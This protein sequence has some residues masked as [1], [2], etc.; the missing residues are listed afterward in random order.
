MSAAGEA[1]A[2]EDAFASGAKPRPAGRVRE[3]GWRPT[4]QRPG[5]AESWTEAARRRAIE[6][7]PTAR[8]IAIQQR[9][10]GRE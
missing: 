6:E 7:R 4:R 10:G 1:K 2:K 8:R 9:C 3:R 5:I